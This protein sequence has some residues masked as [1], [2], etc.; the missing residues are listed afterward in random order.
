MR[1]CLSRTKHAVQAHAGRTE[2]KRVGMLLSARSMAI[3]GHETDGKTTT[4][5]VS[6]DM[7]MS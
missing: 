3:N 6:Q 4:E 7:T 5:Y 1:V 2:V